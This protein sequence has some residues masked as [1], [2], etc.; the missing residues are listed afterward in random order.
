MDIY[1]GEQN[2]HAD[3]NIKVTYSNG[4]EFVYNADNISF[5]YLNPDKI[6]DFQVIKNKE[7]SE[8]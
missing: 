7:Q 5:L 3:G 4:N 1:I 8:D 2:I 6:I